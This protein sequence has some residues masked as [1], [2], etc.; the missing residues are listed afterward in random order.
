MEL[1]ARLTGDATIRKTKDGRE[2]VSFTVVDN[3][4]Y[5]TKAGEKKK[6]ATFFNCAYWVNTTIAG[7]LKKGMIVTL[8][9]RVGINSY[10]NREGDFFAHLIF[11]TNNIKILTGIKES[12]AADEAAKPKDDLPF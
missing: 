5:K 7:H 8:F 2:L 3:H 10:K 1:T 4:Y 9:G 11:H 12:K 6:D